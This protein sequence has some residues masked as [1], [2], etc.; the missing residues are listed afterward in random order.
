MQYW[1]VFAVGLFDVSL[2]LTPSWPSSMMTRVFLSQMQP[3][4]VSKEPFQRRHLVPDAS[5]DCQ[6][7]V[8]GEHAYEGNVR[9]LEAVCGKL[10]IEIVAAEGF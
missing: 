1:V 9:N 8:C 3:A 7:I 10:F 5:E 6:S 4:T 2:M